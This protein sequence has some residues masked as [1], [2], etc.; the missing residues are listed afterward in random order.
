MDLDNIKRSLR[1]EIKRR[2]DEQYLTFQINI[3]DMCKDALAKLEEQEAL[4]NEMRE[5]AKR[6]GYTWQDYDVGE[7]C[8]EDTHTGKWVKLRRTEEQMKNE[9]KPEKEMRKKHHGFSAR[10]L[11]LMALV[12]N[13]RA[14][15][16]EQSAAHKCSIANITALR[17]D[18]YNYQLK[19]GKQYDECTG[20]TLVE[21]W[22]SGQ[23]FI[24]DCRQSSERMMQHR[25][26]LIMQAKRFLERAIDANGVPAPWLSLKLNTQYSRVEA[27]NEYLASCP[28]ELPV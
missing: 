16:W 9:L 24:I 11:Y 2:K 7:D 27:Q 14:S 4:I 13:E 23:Q 26:H 5:A 21:S 3:R 12:A 15:S 10:E 20:K 25:S 22:V 19:D 8:W 18:S 1:S 6:L 17:C 28:K